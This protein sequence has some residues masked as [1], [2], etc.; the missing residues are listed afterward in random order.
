[1][2]R[3]ATT[4]STSTTKNQ[5][6][7]TEYLQADPTTTE[8]SSSKVTSSPTIAPSVGRGVNLY[9]VP[10][11]LSMSFVCVLLGGILALL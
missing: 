3:P 7:H 1:V 9:Q 11:A 6:Q 8:A 4:T 2:T 5:H 10:T